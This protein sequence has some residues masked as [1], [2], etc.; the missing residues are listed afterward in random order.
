MK[1]TSIITFA[2]ILTTSLISAQSLFTP[3]DCA[4]QCISQLAG[5]SGCT[6]ST[7]YACFCRS[8]VFLQE[9]SPCILKGCTAQEFQSTKQAVETLC[10]VAGAP[11]TVNVQPSGATT[12]SPSST[13]RSAAPASSTSPGR[14]PNSAGRNTVTLCGLGGAFAL[15]AVLL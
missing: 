9:F 3:P 8:S 4:I 7:N 1:T 6:D 2:T 14:T 11:V 5:R 15:A 13:A 10:A 12:G